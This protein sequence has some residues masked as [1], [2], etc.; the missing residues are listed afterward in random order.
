MLTLILPGKVRAEEIVIDS[1][2]GEVKAKIDELF[3]PA[4]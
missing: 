2:S 1:K 4:N 3:R